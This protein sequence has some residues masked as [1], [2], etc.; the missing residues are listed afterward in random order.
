YDTDTKL[1]RFGYRDYDAYTGKWTAKDPIDFA[2]GD[3]N[4]YGYVL[5]DP[6]NFVD[7]EGLGTS[8][9][10]PALCSALAVY[11]TAPSIDECRT[12]VWD[13]YYDQINGNQD[14]QIICGGYDPKACSIACTGTEFWNNLTEA[15]TG[16]GLDLKK[17][18]KR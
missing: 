5:G 11:K 2:G 14:Y 4:L 15:C 16:N 12:I 6:V 1:T 7:V 10:G 13:A 18:W 3:T 17:G 8:L 9:A